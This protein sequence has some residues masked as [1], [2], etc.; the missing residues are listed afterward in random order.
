MLKTKINTLLFDLD[1]TLIDRNT[2]MR[3]T[4]Q[5]WL[6]DINYKVKTVE[7]AL[8]EIMKKDD[9]GYM[10]RIDFSTWVIEN[11]GKNDNNINNGKSFYYYTLENIV[12]YFE[13]NEAV[14]SMLKKLA[15]KFKLAVATNGETIAQRRKL[16]KANLYACFKPE[17]IFI[18]ANIGVEKPDKKFFETIIQELKINPLEAL[19][20]GDS[21]I[22]DIQC[23][24]DA[25]LNTCWVS[26]GRTN[27]LS[28]TPDF[29]INE[30]TYFS[31]LLIA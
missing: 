29:I 18:S 10:N 25:G 15:E 3:K 4:M 28:P 21:P 30:I 2:A 8:E 19:M 22:N 24:K 27:T 16:E 26:Y 17:N 12:Q 14:I 9:W 23:S 20:I 13:P 5:Q 11:Y 7:I 31:Q 1:N 6:V